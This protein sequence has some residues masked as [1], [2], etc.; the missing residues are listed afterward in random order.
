M[1]VAVNELA[2]SSRPRSRARVAPRPLALSAQTSLPSRTRMGGLPRVAA[3]GIP[4]PD[5]PTARSRR[6]D[7]FQQCPTM[8]PLANR[9]TVLHECIK[10]ASERSS[11]RGFPARCRGREPASRCVQRALSAERCVP[12]MPDDAPSR[13]SQVRVM[14]SCTCARN[15][16]REEL[17]ARRRR[18]LPRLRARVPM[19]PARA[20]G[21]PMLSREARRGPLSQIAGPC[22][23]FTLRCYASVRAQRARRH[24]PT[25]SGPD[26]DGVLTTAVACS[27][28]GGADVS[29]SCRR[30][31]ARKRLDGR[32]QL[33]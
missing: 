26:G 15:A 18:A 8:S 4:R 10:K 14:I 30:R 23:D 29:I 5:A 6:N 25:H 2:G 13:K 24:A 16:S 33:V 31:S 1:E 32:E 7:A 3:A 28:R 20:L 22:D 19:P 9:R 27:P 12:A 11:V 17:G 21:G